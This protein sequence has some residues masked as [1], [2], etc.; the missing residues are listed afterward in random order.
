[1][2]LRYAPSEFTLLDAASLD[3]ELGGAQQ[4]CEIMARPLVEAAVADSVPTDD[5]AKLYSFA[6]DACELALQLDP[7]ASVDVCADFL[8][9]ASALGK[10]D[11]MNWAL[12]RICEQGEDACLVAFNAYMGSGNGQDIG[13]VGNVDIGDDWFWPGL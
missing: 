7:A 2:S 11:D 4:A 3:R 12:E 5:Q 1:M 13:N 6:G 8:Q 10:S 9:A